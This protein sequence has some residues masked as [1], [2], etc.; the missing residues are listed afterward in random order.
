MIPLLDV[1]VLIALFDPQH[2]HHAVASDWFIRTHK[3]GWATCPIVQNGFVRVVSGHAYPNRITPTD[4]ISRLRSAVSS[5]QHRLM[6]EDITI[7]DA[8]RFAA[9]QVMT[10]KQVTDLYLLGLA[11]RHDVTFATFDRAIPMGNVVGVE[12]RHLTIL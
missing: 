11:V 6:V 7:T 9:I 1:N 2:Q 3:S 12:A 5:P 10:P 8:A 4:A